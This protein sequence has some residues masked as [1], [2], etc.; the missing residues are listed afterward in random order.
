MLIES[1]LKISYI[2]F[3]LL[4]TLGSFVMITSFV[5]LLNCV[6]T[7]VIG[8]II[9]RIIYEGILIKIMIWKNTTEIKQ[10]LK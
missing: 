5:G 6:L 10:K 7:I 4:I 9:L 3:A 1:I 8:N 2:F